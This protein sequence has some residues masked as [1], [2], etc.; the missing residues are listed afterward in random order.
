[1][2]GSAGL[3]APAGLLGSLRS[4]PANADRLTHP[5]VIPGRR[6]RYLV[7]GAGSVSAVLVGF[8]ALSGGAPTAGASSGDGTT[9]VL[10]P[11]T[12]GE[13]SF[14]SAVFVTH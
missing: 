9:P 4:L 7:A 3:T 1:M 5:R 12:A 8:A 11:V 14:L 10:S 13:D 2:A 6:R